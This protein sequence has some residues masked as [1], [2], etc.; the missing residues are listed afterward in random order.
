MNDYELKRDAYHALDLVNEDTGKAHNEFIDSDPSFMAMGK[1]LFFCGLHMINMILI[2]MRYTVSA[3][4]M[5]FYYH[6]IL[7]QRISDDNWNYHK[8]KYLMKTLSSCDKRT[9]RIRKLTRA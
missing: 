7:D 6:Y 1:Y 8:E 4:L 3:D 9:H 2:F 5:V